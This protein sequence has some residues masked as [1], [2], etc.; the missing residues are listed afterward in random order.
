MQPPDPLGYGEPLPYEERFYP[1]GF[2]L[3]LRTNSQDVLAAA[4]HGLGD[5]TPLFDAP[6]TEM[7]VVVRGE[8]GGLPACA[9]RGPVFRAQGHLLAIL[10]GPDNFG[11]CDLDHRFCFATLT[12]G[13]AGDPL[14][15]SFYF[16]DA[17]AYTCLAYRHTTPFHAACVAHQGRGILLVGPPGAGKS[18]LAWACA[19]AGLSFVGDDA[20]W[21]LRPPADPCLV[22]K[23]QRA[24]FRPDIF[25]VL[26]ELETLPRIE[27]VVGIRSFEVS[28]VGVPGLQTAAVCRPWRVVFLSRCDSGPAEVAPL[29]PAEARQRLAQAMVLW[30]PGVWAEQEASVERLLSVEPVELRYSG[31]ADAVDRLRNLA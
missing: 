24:R 10:L 14:Y 5:Y 22:G 16:L 27:T 2:P 28:T 15:A 20:I 12:P 25:A 19:R 6:P 7:R 17:M 18:S 13:V 9:A 30:E 1:V 31:L 4:R 26:P 21:L 11:L 23:P 29:S 3:V 8:A